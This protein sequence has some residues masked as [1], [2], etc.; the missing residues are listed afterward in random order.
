MER[1]DQDP[2]NKHKQY[3]DT[4][5][6]TST[7]INTCT[8]M[9]MCVCMYMY[10]HTHVY[11]C[12]D[13]W[14]DGWMRWVDG[15][16]DMCMHTY[17]HVC[18]L[19]YENQLYSNNHNCMQSTPSLEKSKLRV[20]IYTYMQIHGLLKPSSASARER[21]CCT[22]LMRA[23]S[24]FLSA[25]PTLFFMHNY[26][27]GKWTVEGSHKINEWQNEHYTYKHT[28]KQQFSQCGQTNSALCLA[29]WQLQCTCLLQTPHIKLERYIYILGRS[30]SS[31]SVIMYMYMY[32]YKYTYIQVHT[33]PS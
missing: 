31:S 10:V 6:N 26:K 4:K 20:C 11:A 17:I 8:Y 9:Y 28:K 7:C 12:M 2:Y 23:K 29:L 14:M 30:L 32:M 24:F 15:Q 18:L 13:G 21:L 16:M 19:T 3:R 33:Y 22:L 27:S 25:L 5:K 1:S